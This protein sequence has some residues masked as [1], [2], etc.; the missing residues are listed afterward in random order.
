MYLKTVPEFILEAEKRNSA[1]SVSSKAACATPAWL[2]LKAASLSRGRLLKSCH[3]VTSNVQLMCLVLGCQPF[4]LHT[5]CHFAVRAR[6]AAAETAAVVIARAGVD[7]PSV[8]RGMMVWWQPGDGLGLYS[9]HK[10][11]ILAED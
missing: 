6:R 8:Q 9:W 3:T 2:S 11:H 1:V 4:T 5:Q 10:G 7:V